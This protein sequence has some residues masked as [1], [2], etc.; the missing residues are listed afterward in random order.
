MREA[1]EKVN[2]TMQAY[3]QELNIYQQSQAAK[4]D[5][6][7]KPADVDLQKLA[8][9]LGL[10]YGRTGLVDIDSVQNIADW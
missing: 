4:D 5:S 7:T 3:S 2:S 10:T 1:L 9:Q 6:V 8:D